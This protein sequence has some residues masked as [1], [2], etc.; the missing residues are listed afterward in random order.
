MP[1][2]VVIA[3]AEIDPAATHLIREIGE[4][5]IVASRREAGCVSY[6]YSVDLLDASRLRVI[7]I[8]AS[9]AALR[10]HFATPH[11][12]EFRRDLAASQARIVS[13]RVFELGKESRLPA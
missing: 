13:L 1:Q 2:L 5:M 8:W 4:R 3:E 9:E 6:A 11:M 12:A 10:E 7:E